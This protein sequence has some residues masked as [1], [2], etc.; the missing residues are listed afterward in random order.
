MKCENLFKKIDELND[1]Y[2]S[3]WEDVCNI[4]S[5]SDYKPGV[6]AV[7]KYFVKM[8]E[9]RGWNVEIFEQPVSGDVVCITLNPDAEGQPV[10]L[11]GHLDTV[12][13]IGSFGTP[14]VSRD[15]EKIY[16]PG[17]MDCKGG[18][19]AAFYA[20]DALYK[21]GF[22][23]RP[24]RLIMQTDEEVG[25]RYSNRATINYICES[26]KDSLAFFNLE[27]GTEGEACL[28]RKGIVT[29]TFKVKGVEA[30]SS[31]CAEIGANAICDAAYKI[32]ELEKLKDNDGLTCNC[33]VITGGTVSNTVPGYC[34][35]K[36][37]VRY[38]NAQ[39]LEW[40]H[41][42]V[43]ELA[44]TVHVPGCTCEVNH[45][46]GRIAMELMDRN[47]NLLNDL[48]R[49]CAEN[50]LATLKL[51]SRKG[52]SDAAEVTASGIPCIDSIG[53]LGGLI[54]SPNEYAIIDSLAVSAK[55]LAAYIYC[56]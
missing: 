45:P 9:E 42:Y 54:H 35:F 29:F 24:V 25:S 46:M 53:P 17:V 28:I 10:T 48:N 26:S 27:G 21:C 44:N 20:M 30:H 41:N 47:V 7:G 19:V 50:G 13:P 39:Q 18:V 4:E 38:A 32:I 43:N 36:A 6:D 5:P 31:N 51:G 56:I 11:S 22:T 14:A 23:S 34:E 1:K 55:R 15:D 37:N 3:V 40:I 52:G 2:I 8:A 49:I 12:H 16:G 33:G